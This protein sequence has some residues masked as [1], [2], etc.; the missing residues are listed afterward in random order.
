M[1]HRDANTNKVMQT[2]ADAKGKRNTYFKGGD[3]DP[4][5]ASSKL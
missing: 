4:I 5:N 1:L 3:V 2:S